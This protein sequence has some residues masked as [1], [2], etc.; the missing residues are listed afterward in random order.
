VVPVAIH[1]VESTP[2]QMKHHHTD[3][4]AVAED[5]HFRTPCPEVRPDTPRQETP[6]RPPEQNSLVGTLVWA[7]VADK[8]V[9][10]FYLVMTVVWGVV[11]VMVVAVAV[12]DLLR[13]LENGGGNLVQTLGL[14]FLFMWS[15]RITRE[16]G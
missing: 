14:I 5:M 1:E 10:T 12:T 6:D 2:V 11:V 3:L 4:V 16:A 15:R 8:A 7:V 13:E 9:D